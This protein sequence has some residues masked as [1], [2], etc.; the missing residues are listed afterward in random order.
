[1]A[2]ITTTWISR[3]YTVEIEGPNADKLAKWRVLQARFDD[4]DHQHLLVEKIEELGTFMLPNGA[5]LFS[6]VNFKTTDRATGKSVPGA[7]FLRGPAGCVL[8]FVKCLETGERFIPFTRQT[9]VPVGR[10]NYF[11]LPAG[12]ID[13]DDGIKG[14]MIGEVEEELGINIAGPDAPQLQE[15]GLWVP[16]AGGSDEVLTSFFTEVTLSQAQIDVILQSVHGVASENEQIHVDMLTISQFVDELAHDRIT[17]GK[18]LATLML[19]LLREGH[20]TIA[21]MLEG[22][23]Q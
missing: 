13:K 21:R 16:S 6:L 19:Y 8:V 3:K 15:L 20:V 22:R 11:E 17:D 2:S 5:I 12:M 9:R 14:R 18:A 4:F 7:I 10:F 23:G 1:M